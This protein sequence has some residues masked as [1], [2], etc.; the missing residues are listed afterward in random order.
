[1]DV[2]KSFQPGGLW[3]SLS[4]LKTQCSPLLNSGTVHLHSVMFLDLITGALF[5][6][7]SSVFDIIFRRLLVQLQEGRMR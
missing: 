5:P 6:V 1:V 3:V 2:G 7:I 4:N